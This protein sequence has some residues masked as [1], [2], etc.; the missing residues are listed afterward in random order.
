MRY[1]IIEYALKINKVPD[2]IQ[3]IDTVQTLVIVVQQFLRRGDK[4]VVTVHNLP[5]MALLHF[6][7]YIWDQ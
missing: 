4:F 6:Y 3:V 5:A 7:P 1:V 2:I